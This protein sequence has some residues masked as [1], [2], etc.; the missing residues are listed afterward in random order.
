MAERKSRAADVQ[1]LQDENIRLERDLFESQLKILRFEKGELEKQLDAANAALE[2][3]QTK[4]NRLSDS[5]RSATVQL[6][7][8]VAHA[9]ARYRAQKIQIDRPYYEGLEDFAVARSRSHRGALPP[10]QPL[11]QA[12]GILQDFRQTSR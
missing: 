7:A 3:M 5:F 9:Q 11:Q 6:E 12:V 2:E 1:N 10:R 4:Y 8:D